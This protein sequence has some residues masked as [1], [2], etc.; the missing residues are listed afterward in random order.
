MSKRPPRRADDEI[1]L[2]DIELNPVSSKAPISHHSE[3]VTVVLPKSVVT[4][5]SPPTDARSSGI[6]SHGV[7]EE[8]GSVADMSGTARM[9]VG[10][11]GEERKG[12]AKYCDTMM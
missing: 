2:T 5:P 6:Y 4:T 12:Y 11:S 8:S 10:E 1:D 9:I 3:S 7:A